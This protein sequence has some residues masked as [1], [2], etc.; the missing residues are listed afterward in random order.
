MQ[1]VLVAVI[2]NLEEAKKEKQDMELLKLANLWLQ[3]KNDGL[4]D[5]ILLIGLNYKNLEDLRNNLKPIGLGDADLEVL[6]IENE[7]DLGECIEPIL[8]LWLSNKHPGAVCFLDWK[9]LL[10]GMAFPNLFWWWTGVEEEKVDELSSI[11]DAMESMV[12]YE[13]KSSVATW[14]ELF[15]R[16]SPKGMF[17]SEEASY[18]ISMN[19]IALTRWLNI[20]DEVSENGFFDFDC[21]EAIKS[22]PIDLMRLARDAWQTHTQLTAELFDNEEANQF[23]LSAQ[24][25][26]LCLTGEEA[27]I[28][29]T[30]KDSFGGALPLLYALYSSIWPDYKNPVSESVMDLC[31]GASKPTEEIMP[32]WNFVNE[33]WADIT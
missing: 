24:C 33:G 13:F 5:S 1:L 7:E 10:A 4:K 8:S 19:A 32:Q 29:A 18:E 30:L 25:L 23:E 26:K 16:D 21:Q 6:E 2:R 31:D 17:D 3:R 28:S 9:S 20:Y 11:N 14:L 22:F 15:L 27:S 12:P